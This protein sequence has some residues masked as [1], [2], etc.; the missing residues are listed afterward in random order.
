MRRALI[1]ALGL[2]TFAVLAQEPAAA[3][4]QWEVP[5]PGPE[6]A[7]LDGMVG[8][9]AVNERHEAGLMGPA[10][11]GKG[12]ARVTRGPGGFTLL[13]DYTATAGAMKGMRGHGIL[14][15]DAE[16]KTYKQSWTDSMGPMIVTSAGSWEDGA[17]V[18]LSEGTMMGKPYKERDVSSD[19]TPKGFTLTINMSMDGAPFEKVMTLVYR[20][21]A[22][23][24]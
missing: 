16:A 23:K 14:G 10:G 1:F 18:L 3:P 21:V 22:S 17:L 24:P 20:R 2:S 15:W 19:I 5:K 6:M 4:A 12:V 9:F 11:S 8:T 13:I 7:K